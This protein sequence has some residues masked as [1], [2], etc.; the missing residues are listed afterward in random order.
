MKVISPQSGQTIIET[1]TAVFIMAMG[2]TAALGLAN[3]A[4][5]NSTSIAKQI[6][7]TGLAREGI[8]MVKNM[9]DDNWLN[10]TYVTNCY[11]YTPPNNN[12]TKCYVNWLTKEFNITGAS[13]PD[14]RIVFSNPTTVQPYFSID[15]TAT[16]NKFGVNFCDATKSVACHGYFYTQPVGGVAVGTPA[17]D[18]TL[19]YRDVVITQNTAAPFNQPN[20]SE[21]KVSSRVWWTD[22]RCPPTTTW[23][24]S[25]SC[26][27]ELDTYLTNWKN[28]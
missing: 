21:L 4:L 12:D 24:G 28:Y 15:S 6:I 2:I 13:S 27:I 22:R 18:G 25:G 8:E 20:F 3:Y 16:G 10:D 14:S 26:S 1:L 17:P 19:Y 23:P 9:R 11:D 7:G 5:N